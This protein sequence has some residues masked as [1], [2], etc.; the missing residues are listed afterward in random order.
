VKRLYL[1]RHARATQQSA[2]DDFERSLVKAGHNDARKMAGQFMKM[3]DRPD[4]IIASSANRAFETAEIFAKAFGIKTKKIQPQ[5]E[6]YDSGKNA[7]TSVLKSLDDAIKSAMVVGH[8]PALND[9]AEYLLKNFKDEIPTSGIVAIDLNIES[10]GEL[11]DGVGRLV[12]FRYPALK[13]EKAQESKKI[14]KGLQTSVK[15][16]VEKELQKIDPT[17]VEKMSGTIKKAVARITRKFGKL[18][19]AA[20]KAAAR[21]KKEKTQATAKPKSTLKTKTSKKKNEREST[22]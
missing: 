18:L 8:V 7:I 13:K 6:I 5:R 9:F 17:S 3:A 2:G 1:V 22:T 11:T 19:K 15:T 4:R 14:R 20:E 16:A 12:F 10:W 21:S